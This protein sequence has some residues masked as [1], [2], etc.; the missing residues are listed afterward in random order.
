VLDEQEIA[1][2]ERQGFDDHKDGEFTVQRELMQGPDGQYKDFEL[3][4]LGETPE[5]WQ[6]L[7]SADKESRALTG[8][9]RD[10][11]DIKLPEHLFSRC[12]LLVDNRDHEAVEI[13]LGS[14]VFDVDENGT[15]RRH[16]LTLDHPGVRKIQIDGR[17][18]GTLPDPRDPR[19][20]FLGTLRSEYAPFA[21]VTCLIDVS[22][23]RT[24]RW[25][26]MRYRDTE[27][28]R[29]R[30]FQDHDVLPEL[31]HSDTLT[32][33]HVH[34]IPASV[35]YFL[36]RAPETITRKIT[37]P[38]PGALSHTGDFIVTEL[39]EITEGE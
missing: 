27:K 33:G 25:R 32:S 2:L 26:Q 4:I 29:E 17:D 5:G 37:D 6:Q 9:Y 20:Y 15:F 8:G 18:V 36:E 31:F 3:S 39:Y 7:Y 24:Y 28:L 34:A 38:L 12:D 11:I 1:V 21:R 22:G 23:K 30:P 14:F 35:K 10:A 19:F 16:V 13:T